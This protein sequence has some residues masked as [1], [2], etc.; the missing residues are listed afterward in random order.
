MPSTAVVIGVQLQ[1][2]QV[3]QPYPGSLLLPQNRSFSSLLAFSHR[4][5]SKRL[6]RQSKCAAAR[7]RQPYHSMK[8]CVG[9]PRSF[10]CSKNSTKNLCLPLFRRKS[11]RPSAMESASE[12]WKEVSCSNTFEKCKN[13]LFEYVRK[14]N[15][16]S[17]DLC[18]LVC[19]VTDNGYAAG[20]SLFAFDMQTEKER[21][22]NPNFEA[23][24]HN[25]RDLAEEWARQVLHAVLVANFAQLL[26]MCLE[27]AGFSL[28]PVVV[29]TPSDLLFGCGTAATPWRLTFPTHSPQMKSALSSATNFN[30]LLQR[31]GEPEITTFPEFTDFGKRTFSLP[32]QRNKTKW[33][34][35]V[36]IEGPLWV[37]T[38]WWKFKAAF[39]GCSVISE[40]CWRSIPCLR[41]EYQHFRLQR[42]VLRNA[43][44]E[45]LRCAFPHGSRI[46]RAV[47]ECVD[48]AHRR[49]ARVDSELLQASLWTV[50]N[51][52][53]R[54]TAPR[55]FVSAFSLW[56]SIL[57][58]L[59]TA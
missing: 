8:P 27:A 4:T 35:C 40:P 59:L 13:Y 25:Q 52:I 43:L 2:V 53:Q 46:G 26:S 37:V 19:G 23:I 49:G 3:L 39:Q 48:G 12:D 1:N 57:A 29:S 50:T 16:T 10:P 11:R 9:G 55:P 18:K 15:S 21:R 24:A 44:R 7:M 30:E 14:L 56:V 42:D 32:F 20:L 54:K 38:F 31:A 28:A 58:S 33:S 41:P 6:E 17:G 36:V 34:P 22:G 45:E 51:W 5:A 47:C